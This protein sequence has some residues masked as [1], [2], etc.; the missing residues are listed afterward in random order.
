L[1]L[2]RESKATLASYGIGDRSTTDAFGRCCLLARRLA[3][4]GVRFI[5]ISAPKSWDDHKDLRAELATNCAMTDRPIAGLLADLK[6]HGM[7]NDTLVIWGGEF[8]RQ[9]MAQRED[10]RDHNNKGFTMWLAGGG[11]K[12]GLAYG[13]TDDYGYAAAENAVHV[14]DLHATVLRL[15]GLDHERLTFRHAGR[16][17]RLTDVHGRVVDGILA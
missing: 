12:G 1:D 9:P 15:L 3:Q 4:S 13:R 6:R 14:H 17:F 7:L 16:D 11:T 8:G 2:G 5:E 10:G